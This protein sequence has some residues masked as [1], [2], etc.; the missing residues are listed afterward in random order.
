M[1][2]QVCR[3][4]LDELSVEIWKASIRCVAGRNTSGLIH[5]LFRQ[6]LGNVIEGNDDLRIKVAVDARHPTGNEKPW[7]DNLRLTVVSL[8]CVLQCLASQVHPQDAM[9]KAGPRDPRSR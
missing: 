4:E 1:R 9:V 8:K 6:D 5:V 7:Q 2:S 3:A